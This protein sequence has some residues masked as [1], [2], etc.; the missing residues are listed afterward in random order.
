[1]LFGLLFVGRVGSKAPRTLS[2]A[3]STSLYARLF[4]L[5]YTVA[6]VTNPYGPGQP[7]SRTA[8]GIVNR[9]IHLALDPFRQIAG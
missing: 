2:V 1:M 4:G 9:L 8:Y 3:K 6:R 5:D 7:Q